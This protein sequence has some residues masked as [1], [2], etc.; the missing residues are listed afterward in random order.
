MTLWTLAVKPVLSTQSNAVLSGMY[1]QYIMEARLDK[2][3]G[4]SARS[5]FREAQEAASM[6]VAFILGSKHNFTSVPFEREKH[7]R[8]VSPF[9]KSSALNRLS[10]VLL[11]PRR[12]NR[13][14]RNERIALT[15]D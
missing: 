9:R 11:I 2:I 12:I 13:L 1:L 7:L 3:R 10:V 15:Q 6:K 5:A 8:P 4:N 14:F